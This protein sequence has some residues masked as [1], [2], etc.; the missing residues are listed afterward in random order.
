M[1]VCEC[2]AMA[3]R[4]CHQRTAPAHDQKW[5]LSQGLWMCMWGP[6]QNCRA[7]PE[8]WCLG[9]SARFVLECEINFLFLVRP[10]FENVAQIGRGS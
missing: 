10:A 4:S 1:D 2:G 9:R 3:R 7:E 5:L 6:R 8:E